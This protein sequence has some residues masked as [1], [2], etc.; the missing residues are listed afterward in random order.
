MCEFSESVSRRLVCR[1]PRLNT[2]AVI[3]LIYQEG[4]SVYVSFCLFCPRLNLAIK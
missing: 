3:A 1:W 4:K 2:E